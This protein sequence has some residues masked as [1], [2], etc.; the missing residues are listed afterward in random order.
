MLFITW[1]GSRARCCSRLNMLR[2]WECESWSSHLH[3]CVD[4]K[5]LDYFERLFESTHAWSL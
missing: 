4:G 1:S 5:L 3:A 2:R